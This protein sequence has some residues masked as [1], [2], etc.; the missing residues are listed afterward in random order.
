MDIHPIISRMACCALW[1]NY[2]MSLIDLCV[3]A[4]APK[5]WRSFQNFWKLNILY[6]YETKSHVAQAKTHSLAV[7][8]LEFLIFPPLPLKCWD[9]RCVLLCSIVFFIFFKG[10]V[11]PCSP[12]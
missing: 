4:L 10:Q 9:F 2:E 12:G 6:V 8:N 5:W 7:D 3:E 11:L 1:F